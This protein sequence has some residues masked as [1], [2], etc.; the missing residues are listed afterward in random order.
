MEAQ[1]QVK[2]VTEPT[3]DQLHEIVVDVF[4]DL[5]TTPKPTKPPISGDTDKASF[6]EIKITQGGEAVLVA[7][8]PPSVV[9]PAVDVDAYDSQ[10]NYF[11]EYVMNPETLGTD[12]AQSYKKAV[13]FVDRSYTDK[14]KQVRM[15]LLLWKVMN[16]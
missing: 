5:K 12:E 4:K 15:L 11:K 16:Y 1:E 6:S 13:Q 9:A 8:V 7:P 14:E 3:S 10:L 2:P